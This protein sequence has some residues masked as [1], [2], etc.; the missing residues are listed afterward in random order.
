MVSGEMQQPLKNF[1]SF[2][3]IDAHPLSFF[4]DTL[5]YPTCPNWAVSQ[6][7][8]FIFRSTDWAGPFWA[9][10]H[11]FSSF[12]SF[13]ADK[14]MSAKDIWQESSLISGQPPAHVAEIH[15]PFS[16]LSTG[17]S[18]QFLQHVIHWSHF[19]CPGNKLTVSS[20]GS[21]VLLRTMD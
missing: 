14:F 20:V 17:G 6:R 19:H 3:E 13:R 1:T 15:R 4:T 18:A 2:P 5:I 16:V 8:A 21:S 12:P 9:K 7:L 11:P 10:V